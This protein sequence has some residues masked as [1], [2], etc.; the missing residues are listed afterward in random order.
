M[1]IIVANLVVSMVQ[2]MRN[3]DL[4]YYCIN[5]VLLT[6]C[7]TIAC[8]CVGLRLSLNS[9]IGYLSSIKSYF[10]NLYRKLP[11]PPVFQK[12]HWSRILSCVTSAY[13]EQSKAT[14][15]ALVNPHDSATEED[16]ISMANLC[17]WTGSA[18]Y[19]NF[20]FLTTTMVHAAG[21]GSEVALAKLE[22]VRTRYIDEFTVK[23]TVLNLVLNRHKT[24]T[25]QDLHIY[26]HKVRSCIN[27]HVLF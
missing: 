13:I 26:P 17:A 22:H 4:H 15:N 19:A 18:K 7:C 21:R 27:T 14:G 6:F 2:V 5:V 20:H 12:E 9:S 16:I 11:T 24:G 8:P 25:V 10:L 3:R 1:P 23:A